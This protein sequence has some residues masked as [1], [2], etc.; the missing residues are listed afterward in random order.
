MKNI[1]IKTIPH[2]KQRYNTTGDWKDNGN[3]W[4]IT[5]SRN[6]NEKYEFLVAL[7]EF[8]ELMLCYFNDISEQEATNYDLHSNSEDP[9][10]EKDCPYRFAHQ[11]ATKIEKIV[12]KK[13]KVNFKKYDKSISE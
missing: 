1:T 8:I 7:H 4:L 6:Y 11:F 9:G 2:K 10:F 3:S 13:I 5:V 12:A